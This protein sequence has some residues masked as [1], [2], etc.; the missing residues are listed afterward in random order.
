MLLTACRKHG[1]SCSAQKRTNPWGRNRKRPG[2]PIKKR[3][4][5]KSLFQTPNAP[6]FSATLP[7]DGAQSTVGLELG[8]VGDELV[9]VNSWCPYGATDRRKCAIQLSTYFK[10]CSRVTVI[11]LTWRSS[12]VHLPRLFTE[13]ILHDVHVTVCVHV[14]PQTLPTTKPTAQEARVLPPPSIENVSSSKVSYT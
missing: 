7:S 4:L 9:G 10:K 6:L 3:I 13:R 14:Q 12:T 8:D 2:N 11:V 1:S 5:K